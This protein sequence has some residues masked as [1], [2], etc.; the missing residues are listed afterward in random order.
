M[1]FPRIVLH[2]R[3]MNEFHREVRLRPKTSIGRAGVIDARDAGMLQTTQRLRLLFETAQQLRT[4]EAG[5]DDLEGDGPAQMIL[6][7]FI[8]RAHAAFADKSENPVASD[9][10]MARGC[11]RS[12]QGPRV[13]RLF[14]ER[15]AIGLS[16]Y[17]NTGIHANFH[18]A[19]R[20]GSG[21]RAGLRQAAAASFASV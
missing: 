10:R 11:S 14:A 2:V 7:S 1:P 21:Q 20:A 16:R 4:C 6:F 19:A 5:L 17:P 8:N 9:N 12:L 18:H 15:L 13:F 3:A